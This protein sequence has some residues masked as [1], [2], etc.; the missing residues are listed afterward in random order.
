[1]D[2]HPSSEFKL[3]GFRPQQHMQ[4]TLLIYDFVHSWNISDEFNICLTVAMMLARHFNSDTLYTV[5]SGE[6]SSVSYPWKTIW[7]RHSAKLVCNINITVDVIKLSL[8][9]KGFMRKLETLQ[10]I[11][12][13]ANSTSLFRYIRIRQ[14][15]RMQ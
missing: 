6:V 3:S 8:L 1:M 11:L 14:L 9:F 13:H 10:F 7:L 4:D 15:A 5:I 2:P 12:K